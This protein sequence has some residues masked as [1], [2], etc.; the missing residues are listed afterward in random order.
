MRDNTE[1]MELLKQITAVE[2]MKEDLALYL[3]THPMDR[4]A[5]KRYNAYVMEG[6][7]LKEKYEMNYG[8]LCEHDSPSP[9]PWQ[10]INNP[11]P[12]ESEANFELDKEEM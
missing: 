2:F 5:I 4:E 11:W 12:W 9:Y 7:A 8:M 3:N 1:K 6:K 10:W